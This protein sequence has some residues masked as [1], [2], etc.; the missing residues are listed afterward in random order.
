MTTWQPI[1]E[2]PKNIG[3]LVDIWV[4]QRTLVD[5]EVYSR[6]A[7]RHA[8]ASWIDWSNGKPRW[9]TYNGDDIEYRNSDTDPETGGVIIVEQVVTHFSP[10]PGP[11]DEETI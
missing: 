2:C 9:T 8:D 1:N 6:W 7:G 5:G 3:E 4:V 10:Y 11:H